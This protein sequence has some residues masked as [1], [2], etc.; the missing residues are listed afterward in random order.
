MFSRRFPFSD[1]DGRY[2]LSSLEFNLAYSCNLRCEHCDHFSPY[3]PAPESADGNEI[4]LSG[5]T[6]SIM[7][8]APHVSVE[9]F[10]FL[11]GEPLLNKKIGF[12]VEALKKSG[13]AQKTWLVT[14]G[15]LLL[16][17]PLSLLKQFDC[18][19][20]VVY[21]SN[22]L[23]ASTLTEIERLCR[24]AGIKLLL[25]HFSHFHRSFVSRRHEKGFAKKIFLTCSLAWQQK[26][27]TLYNG[28]LC[29]CSR[30]PFISTRL[31]KLGL[32][33]KEFL[34]KDSLKIEPGREMRE[35]IPHY[36]TSTET[37]ESCFYCLARMGKADPHRQLT[38]HDV[39]DEIWQEVRAK[40]SVDIFDLNKK[41]YSRL[42]FPK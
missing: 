23:P 37:P 42:L 8:L 24:G 26:C 36:F 11:G 18:I 4:S 20:I 12:F 28:H 33:E 15:F 9:D 10:F 39:R 32:V 14:N 7:H 30:I 41:Y 34:E 2:Q 21:K 3:F 38:D 40:D 6:E 1:P 19:R 25:Y 5:F 22:P 29:R 13:L 35:K 31:K 16:R 17:Q 27:F